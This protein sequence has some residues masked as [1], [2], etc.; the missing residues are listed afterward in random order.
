MKNLILIFFSIGL[1]FIS[2]DDYDDPYRGDQKEIQFYDINWNAAVDSSTT[3]FINR[4]WS[5]E[6]HCFASL[7][8]GEIFF[9]SYWPEAHALDVMVDAYLRTNGTQYRQNIYDWYEGVRKK[10]WYPGGNWKNEFNDDMGWHCLAH[11]RAFE[12]TGDNRFEGS[13]QNLWNWITESWTDYDGG[14]IQWKIGT[15]TESMGKGIPANGPAA[16]IAARRYKKYPTEIVGGMDNLEWAKRIY[17]WMKYYRTILSSGRVFE[18]IGD[19]NGD[20]SYN[21]GTYLGAAL[22]LYDIT[23]DKTYWNDALRITNYHL[24]YNI[25]REYGVMKDHGEQPGP[26][27]EGHDCNLFKGIFVRYFTILIQHPDLTKEDKSRYIA[28]LENNAKYL[29]TVGTQKY[30]DIK[31]SYCWWETPAEGTVWGDVNSA[32][33]AAMTIEAMALLENKGLLQN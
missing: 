29:W 27:G 1:L 12:A 28:F 24:Q 9:N 5:P 23:G 2:C 8:D 4:Y 22:E 3:S 17:D 19:T 16:I 18:R 20:Y 14:G 32:I 13:S 15:D 6:F 21:V 30:P 10:N 11:M 26:S 33:S 7:Y 25:N 31:F